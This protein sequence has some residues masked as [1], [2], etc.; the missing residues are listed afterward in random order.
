MS[1]SKTT[2]QT[3]SFKNTYLKLYKNGLKIVPFKKNTSKKY[4]SDTYLSDMNP[5]KPIYWNIHEPINI[6]K[7]L[8][9]EK[10]ITYVE[11]NSIL[12]LAKCRFLEQQ[13]LS[14]R[15]RVMKYETNTIHDANTNTDKEK[16]TVNYKIDKRTENRKN[17]LV[18][19]LDPA[20]QNPIKKSELLEYKESTAKSVD[21]KKT[22]ALT[23]LSRIANEMFA[24]LNIVFEFKKVIEHNE[25]VIGV[26]V[27][28]TR[29]S[30]SS[31]PSSSGPSSSGSSS[32]GSSSSGPS[33]SEP[34]TTFLFYNGL[35]SIGRLNMYLTLFNKYKKKNES[36]YVCNI[37]DNHY[38]EAIIDNSKKSLKPA[39]INLAVNKLKQIDILFQDIF[40]DIDTDTYVSQGLLLFM[41]S[42][43]DH[44]QAVFEYEKILG[45]E[46]KEVYLS[47]T[48][49]V[50]YSY[51]I[52]K[53]KPVVFCYTSLEGKLN[54]FK[55]KCKS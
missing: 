48:D 45:E 2:T 52:L 27:N 49:R 11:D 50:L 26:D 12:K 25:T 24:K 22:A 31:G 23:D 6:V 51:C 16:H 55:E 15:S 3:S 28:V 10:N 46:G 9:S 14:D 44:S 43:G 18:S 39:D 37:T 33:S 36:F 19:I 53:N 32:S 20:N 47:T 34:R 4:L 35:F 40:K 38:K 41:K 5:K 30:S 54:D 42:M 29:R 8:F 13:V 21:D 7:E 17:S 1:Y